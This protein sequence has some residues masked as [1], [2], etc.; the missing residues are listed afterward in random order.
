[1]DQISLFNLNSFFQQVIDLSVSKL[2][3]V[4]QKIIISTDGDLQILSGIGGLDHI[5]Q[6]LRVEFHLSFLIGRGH[7]DKIF[8]EILHSL[9]KG[10]VHLVLHQF[11][12]GKRDPVESFDIYHK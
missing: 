10:G 5:G 4:S 6:V 7:P 8:V 11:G 1:M 9:E 12:E 2:A 3:I